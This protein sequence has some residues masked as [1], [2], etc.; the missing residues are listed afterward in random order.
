MRAVPA[1]CTFWPVIV[2]LP[3]STPAL[4]AETST[5]PA[6]LTVPLAPPSRMIVPSACCVT[7]RAWTT[8]VMLMT[9]S[10]TPLA[11][12]A[13]ISTLPPSA[14]MMPEFCTSAWPWPSAATV[15][16]S[17]TASLTRPSP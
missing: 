13:V 4:G 14:L 8:P 16:G 3:A 15:T 6:T 5:V 12:L 9:V 10:T 1:S 2:T 7:R 17:V 11:A